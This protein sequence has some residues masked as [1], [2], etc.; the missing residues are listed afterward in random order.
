MDIEKYTKGFNHGYV[1]KKYQ[2]ELYNKL[3]KTS[4]KNNYLQGLED[5]GNELQREKIKT[6]TRLQQLKNLDQSKDRGLDQGIEL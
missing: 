3:I 6:L 2:P 4:I 5:G 1:I